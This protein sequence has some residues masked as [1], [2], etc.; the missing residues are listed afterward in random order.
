M[1]KATKLTKA[2]FKALNSNKSL[3]LWLCHA[4]FFVK[5]ACDN[6]Q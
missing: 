6:G 4:V 3:N 2:S 1:I 5:M